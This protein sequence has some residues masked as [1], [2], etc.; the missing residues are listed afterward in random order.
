MG[1]ETLPKNADRLCLKVNKDT[2]R[3]NRN[4]HKWISV[5]HRN[6]GTAQKVRAKIIFFSVRQW[7]CKVLIKIYFC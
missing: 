3:I 5:L 6:T 7:S 1:L 2:Q 4:C